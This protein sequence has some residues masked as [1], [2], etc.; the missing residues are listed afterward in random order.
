MRKDL[1]CFVVV[2]AQRQMACD[3]QPDTLNHAGAWSFQ[4]CTQWSR[5]SQTTFIPRQAPTL[6]IPFSLRLLATSFAL[7]L[8]LFILHFDSQVIR[9][10]VSQCASS[11]M[12]PEVTLPRTNKHHCHFRCTASCKTINHD[13]FSFVVHFFLEQTCHSVF[14]KWPLWH[15]LK[16][17]PLPPRLL[18]L[19]CSKA[20][21]I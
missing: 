4:R 7:S 12:H 18:F 2:C 20:L 13:V 17:S 1:F 3:F 10:G 14:F 21:I 11:N 15:E 6:D 16:T 8:V 19:L 5:N 9:I